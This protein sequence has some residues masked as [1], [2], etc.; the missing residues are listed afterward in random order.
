MQDCKW[1]PSGVV[2]NGEVLGS[3]P[4]FS[5]LTGCVLVNCTG[6]TKEAVGSNTTKIVDGDVTGLVFFSA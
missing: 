6:N 2:Q 4:T 3:K 5:R 1:W